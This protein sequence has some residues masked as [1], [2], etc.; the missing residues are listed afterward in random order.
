MWNHR[1]KWLHDKRVGLHSKEI[2]AIDNAINFEFT[3]GQNG[4]SSDYSRL[5][6]GQVT[7][8]V[9]KTVCYKV[10]WLASV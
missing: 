4:L 7:D 5:F 9:N 8:L 10:Q 6:T 1:N 3:I 2:Q